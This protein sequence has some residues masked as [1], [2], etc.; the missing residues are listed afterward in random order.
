MG[1]FESYVW[2]LIIVVSISLW[3]KYENGYSDEGV[4]PKTTELS[5]VNDIGGGAPG[6][7]L[8]WDHSDWELARPTT[9]R[10]RGR[11]R[12]AAKPHDGCEVERLHSREAG[13]VHI[14]YNHYMFGHS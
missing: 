7:A 12:G 2:N 11:G 14:P 6:P 3:T 1:G 8:R 13:E 5:K 9:G 4:L 10:G